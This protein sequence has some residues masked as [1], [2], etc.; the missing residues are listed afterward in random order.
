MESKRVD[1]ELAKEFFLTALDDLK[2]A[3]LELDGKIFNNSIYHSQQ[4]VEKAI[5]ALLILHN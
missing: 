4:A 1:K 3:K 5:K 2:S